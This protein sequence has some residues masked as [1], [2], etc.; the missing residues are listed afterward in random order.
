ME[1]LKELLG[2]ELYNQVTSKL[3]DIKVIK[4][5]GNMIPKSRFDEVNEQKKEYKKMIDERD[6]QLKDLSEKAKGN[7]EL[8][9]QI[10]QLKEQNSNT[11]KKFEEK[12]QKQAFDF[13]L[14][15]ALTNAKAKNVKALKALLNMEN[16]KLDGENLLGLEDQLKTLQESDAYLFDEDILSGRKPNDKGKPPGGVKNPWSKEHFNL[17]EQGKLLKDDPELAKQLQAQA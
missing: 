3:G 1:W 10:E 9:K 16:I 11:S 4:D 17:T 6:K 2:E 14:E 5:D 13:S 15:K 12:L 8:S 7:E